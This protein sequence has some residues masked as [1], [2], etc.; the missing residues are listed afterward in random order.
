MRQRLA[1]RDVAVHARRLQ[2]DADPLGAGR[3]GGA[4]GPGRAPRR[5]RRRAAG[6]PR[7][8]R[9]SSSCRRRWGRA[10]RRPRRARPRSRCPR[11]ASKRPVGLAQIAHEDRGGGSGHPFIQ[12]AR[13]ALHRATALRAARAGVRGLIDIGSNTTRLLVAEPDPARPGALVEVAAHRAFV[14][15]T[16]AER[17]HRHPA[18]KGSGDRRRGRRAGAGRARQRHRRAARRRDR[19]AARRAR[20]RRAAGAPERGGGRPGRGAQRGG[21]GAAGFAGATAA[22]AGPTASA[23][24][25]RRRR[26]R[27]DRAG[28]AARPAARR[29][30][31]R[32]CRS[33]P[34]RWP[35][36]TCTATRRRATSW[37]AARAEAAAAIAAAGCPRADVAWA[38]GGSATSL[39]RLCGAS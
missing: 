33:A 14:R 22:L 39:R 26:R 31:G 29:R 13:E 32:R 23:A 27:L 5:C 17:A 4:R 12:A 9:R 16:A 6:S 15:L 24:C 19:G 28:R 2:D 11:T 21:G 25:R 38:V 34:A 8:S 36:P 7:G 10:G 18:R 37:R 3:A 30:G 1:D 35:R 20:P